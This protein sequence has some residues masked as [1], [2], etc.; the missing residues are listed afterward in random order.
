MWKL[1]LVSRHEY[2]TDDDGNTPYHTFVI[3]SPHGGDGPL[4]QMHLPQRPLS[5]V[6]RSLEKCLETNTFFVVGLAYS[7]KARRKT[8]FH[9][10]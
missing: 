7:T 5:M 4:H 1:T 9:I 10:F 3:T 8:N 2:I 6:V